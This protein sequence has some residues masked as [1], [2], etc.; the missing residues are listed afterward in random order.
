MLVQ[1]PLMLLFG[2]LRWLLF[3][4]TNPADEE[5]VITLGAA[6]LALVSGGLFGVGFVG[7]VYVLS[8]FGD[9]VGTPLTQANLVVASLWSI[10]AFREIQGVDLICIFVASSALVLCGVTLLAVFN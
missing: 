3:A 1:L 4:R 9:A 5:G 8:D 10:I 7:Q 6:L 2:G